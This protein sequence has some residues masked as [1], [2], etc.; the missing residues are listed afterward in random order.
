MGGEA[1]EQSSSDESQVFLPLNY[2]LS[3]I[4]QEDWPKPF[5]GFA[6]SEVRFTGI[7]E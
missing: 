2:D 3:A 7:F 1:S 4:K 5:C 6:V